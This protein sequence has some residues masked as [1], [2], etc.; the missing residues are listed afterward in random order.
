MLRMQLPL[1]PTW[2]PTWLVV[3][4]TVLLEAA[5]AGAI[6]WF[7]VRRA[8]NKQR[9]RRIFLGGLVV[10]VSLH[11]VG[12]LDT[13]LPTYYEARTF[14]TPLVNGPQEAVFLMAWQESAIL[15]RT[16]ARSVHVEVAWP[17]IRAAYPPGVMP[18]DGRVAIQL[19]LLRSST[20]RADELLDDLWAFHSAPD[21]KAT[22]RALWE[23]LRNSPRVKTDPALARFLEEHRPY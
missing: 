6:F 22:G 10:A 17:H 12:A 8:E 9:A 4:N 2:V 15:G 13:L 19:N 7:I 14:T 1:A 5:L 18:T 3:V 16:V 21:V 23:T 11:V 20:M